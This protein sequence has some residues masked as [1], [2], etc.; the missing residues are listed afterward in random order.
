MTT[1]TARAGLLWFAADR[2]SWAGWQIR[3]L[4]GAPAPGDAKL[5]EHLIAGLTNGFS[6]DG[7]LGEDLVATATAVVQLADLGHRYPTSSPTRRWLLAR[8]SQPGAFHLGCTAARHQHRSCEHFLDGF[9]SPAPPSRRMAP[10]TVPNGRTYR[11]ESQARFVSSIIALEAVVRAGWTHELLVE[12][13]LDSLAS[14]VDEWSGWGEQLPPDLAFAS[15]AALAAAPERWRP[16]RVSL[17]QLVGERQQADGTWPRVDF[18][19]ALDGLCRLP[20]EAA[21]AVLRRSAPL[22]K[23]RQHE[24]GSFGTISAELR[25]LIAARALYAADALD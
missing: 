6:A 10:L 23:L 14:L 18:F 13:H 4:L 25:A 8:Q 2:G 17:V 21:K 24:D 22:L 1:R 7:S 20:D 16:I 5:R 11:L 15:L 12:R 19:A 9:F 3:S